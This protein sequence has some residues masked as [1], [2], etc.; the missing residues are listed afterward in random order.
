MIQ[1][2]V[3]IFALRAVRQ[4]SHAMS[5]L[6]QD[7]RPVMA[8]L[9]AVSSDAARVSGVAAAQVATFD[10]LLSRVRRLLDAS[11]SALQDTIASIFPGAATGSARADSRSRQP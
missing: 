3:I 2:A 9:Q 6:E 1:V 11:L 7:M 5:R 8:N 4:V 10:Q